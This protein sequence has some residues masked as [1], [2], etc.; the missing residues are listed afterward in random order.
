MTSCVI[1]V[2]LHDIPQQSVHFNL[3]LQATAIFLLEKDW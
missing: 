2:H 1:T 3:A